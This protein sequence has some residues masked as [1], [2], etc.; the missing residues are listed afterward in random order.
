MPAHMTFQPGAVLAASDLND[1]CNPTTAAHIPYA[2][3]TGTANTPATTGKYARATITFPVARFSKPPVVTA[4]LSTGGAGGTDKV[5]LSVGNVTT[6]GAELWFWGAAG[7]TLAD[8][9]LQAAW[10]AVQMTA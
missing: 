6:N 3:Q 1:A 5:I 10:I 2:V 4:T 9:T 7:T 8:A